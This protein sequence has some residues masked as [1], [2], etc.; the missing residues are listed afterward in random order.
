[1]P[2]GAQGTAEVRV[3]TNGLQ[4]PLHVLQLSSWVVVF[5]D[6]L[7][8]SI[9][10]IPLIESDILKVLISACFSVSVI[11]L[12]LAA[13]QATCCDPADPH[14]RRQDHGVRVNK[15]EDENLP[16]CAQ[17][18]STVFS[19][20]KHCRACNKCVR[21]F[22]HHCMWVNN[23]VGAQNYR[24]FATCIVS[25]AVMTANILGVS[26]YLLLEF[27]IDDQ[28]F[29]SRWVKHFLFE[30]VAKEVALVPFIFLAVVNCPFFVLDMQLVLLHIFLTWQ[31]VTTYEYIMNKRNASLENEYNQ[32]ANKSDSKGGM[33]TLPRCLDWI[34]IRR[35]RRKQDANAKAGKTAPKPDTP[36]ASQAP[37]ESVPPPPETVPSSTAPPVAETLE[38][39]AMWAT[40][41]SGGSEPLENPDDRRTSPVLYGASLGTPGNSPMV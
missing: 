10:G 25:V 19:R 23:C 6:V 24:A 33:R 20:S 38:T 39:G 7:L 3:R 17:C 16:Y 26:G 18:D 14:I 40:E 41:G 15:E 4:K 1:M 34:V 28:E 22:D 31:N 29:E 8:F 12:V 30:N 27:F 13:I 11:V 2:I 5:L 36:E 9:I 21:E 35:R 37:L 32:D